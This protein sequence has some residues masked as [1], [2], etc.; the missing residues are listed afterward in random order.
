MPTIM[1][2]V[3]NREVETLASASG[4]EETWL[5]YMGEY[6]PGD[7]LCVRCDRPNQFLILCLDGFT[8][9]F[10]YCKGTHC[11]YPVPFG[12]AKKAVSPCAFVGTRHY[13][14]ARFAAPQ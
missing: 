10:V 5:V 6:M 12:E 13:L 11:T 4:N 9:A 8:H 3:Q 7:Q 14:Y 1:I 2:S